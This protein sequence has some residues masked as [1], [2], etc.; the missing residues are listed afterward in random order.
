MNFTITSKELPEK[1]YPGMLISYTVSPLLRI[2]MTWLAEITQVEEQELFIDEQRMGPYKM[3]HHQHFLEEI[4]Q[5]VLMK[6][7]VSYIPPLGIVGSLAN[8]LIIIPKLEE[9][10]AYRK[11][12]LDKKFG[13]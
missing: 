3:W 5:G 12:A 4:H 9:I 2:P 10:F 8:R 7:I 11:V 6:D 13:F 1:I